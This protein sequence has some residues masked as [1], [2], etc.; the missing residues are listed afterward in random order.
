MERRFL[1]HKLGHGFKVVET[2]GRIKPLILPDYGNFKSWDDLF[3]Y[4]NEE[5]G[6][7]A[8]ALTY[9]ADEISR[10]GSGHLTIVDC[11]E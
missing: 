7:S 1:I 4:L 5:I 9:C 3:R 8:A 2:L 6:A 10:L 11:G